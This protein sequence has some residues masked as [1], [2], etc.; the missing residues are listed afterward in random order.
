LLDGQPESIGRSQTGEPKPKPKPFD[1]SKQVVYLAW[2]KVKENQGAAGVDG[3]AIEDFEKDLKNNLFRIWN[4][5]SS[6]SYFPP[7]V[8]AVEIPK[9]GG[10]VRVL[11]VPTVADRVAQTVASMYLERVVEPIFH[12]DSYG[13]RPNRSALD[14]VASCRRRCWEYAWAVD[15]D[16]Q[17]FFDTIDHDLLLRAVS[18]HATA[19]WI[20]LYVRRWLAAPILQTDG[21]LAERDRGSPQGSAITPPTQWATSSSM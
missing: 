18:K 10:G 14:A 4:R 20:V 1:I 8:R 17:K 13:Y 12:S 5:M 9:S 19:P 16:V 6:G 11:G 3:Q 7:P 21:N 15:L 2:L